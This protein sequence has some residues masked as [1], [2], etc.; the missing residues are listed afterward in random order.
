YQADCAELGMAAGQDV[1]LAV[2]DT[3]AL[4]GFV[5]TGVVGEDA[6]GAFHGVDG[7]GHGEKVGDVGFTKVD[8]QLGSSSSEILQVQS[9]RP[10]KGRHGGLPLRTAP[11]RGGPGRAAPRGYPPRSRAAPDPPLL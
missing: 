7:F 8:A 4:A 3:D 11:T 2:W 9:P 5:G 1:E 6:E 10:T